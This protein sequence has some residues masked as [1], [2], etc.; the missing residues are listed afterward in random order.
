M[1]FTC[2]GHQLGCS[3]TATTSNAPELPGCCSESVCSAS[4][5]VAELAEASLP[6]RHH[7]VLLYSANLLES[8][9]PLSQAGAN[10]ARNNQA[11]NGTIQEEDD[12][13]LACCSVEDIDDQPT[14]LRPDD[15]DDDNDS[16]HT[17]N[18]SPQVPRSI[19]V[20]AAVVHRSASSSSTMQSVDDDVTE[21]TTL[22]YSE[23]EWE[24]RGVKIIMRA[25]Q[26]Q[27]DDDANNSVFDVSRMIG[28]VLLLILVISSAVT[29]ENVDECREGLEQ[30][31]TWTVQVTHDLLVWVRG[32]GGDAAPTIQ[33]TGANV[34]PRWAWPGPR[35]LLQ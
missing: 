26:P 22:Y 14:S 12:D 1:S 28:M 4:S 30:V 3:L 29:P 9:T 13:K 10:A 6:N 34:V 17:T 27:H 5:V 8:A 16:F 33:Q 18:L 20:Q 15:D 24:E 21:S 25:I 11:T 19:Q 35:P 32:Q 7:R 2:R 31:W 23:E